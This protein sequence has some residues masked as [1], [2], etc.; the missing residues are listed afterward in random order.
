MGNNSIDSI[1]KGNNINKA[2]IL[3]IANQVFVDEIS[4]IKQVQALLNDDLSV[5]FIDAVKLIYA[6]MGK[7]VVTG[8]GKSGHIGSKIASTLASTGTPAFFMHPAEALHGDLGMIEDKDVVIA[9]SYSGESEELSAILPILKRRKIPMVAITSNLN[10]SLA[11][12][13]DYVL[14]V[15]VDKEACPLGLAPTTSTTACLVLGD[16]LAVCLYTI[17]GF[18]PEDFAVSHPGGTLG[19]KLLTKVRDIMHTNELLPKVLHTSSLKDVVMEMSNKGLGLTGVIDDSGVLVGVVTDGDLR[20]LLDHHTDIFTTKAC[21]IM[22]KSP[23]TVM[24]DSLAI[25]AVDLMEKIQITGFLVVNSENK[26]IG[27]FNLH[28]LFKAR[29]L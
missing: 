10:S 7:I 17:R 8:M 12:I 18:K 25:E 9:I 13:A 16:A 29:L 20:R 19:R 4:G 3:Q 5:N 6:C 23:K 28:D 1:D 24:A 2:Q 14:N 27:A 15:K 22:T 21:D 26:L 11:K